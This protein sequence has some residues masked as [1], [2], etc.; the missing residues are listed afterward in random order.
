[1]N[2]GRITVKLIERRTRTGRVK[3]KEGKERV[4]ERVEAEGDGCRDERD[5][6]G[7][8]QSD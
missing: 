8:I 5:G 4:R 3:E 2:R 7:M 6:I 1:M